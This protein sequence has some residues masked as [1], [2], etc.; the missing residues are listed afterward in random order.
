MILSQRKIFNIF[1]GFIEALSVVKICP[2]TVADTLMS[3]YHT[4]TSG[5]TDYTLTYLVLT[6]NN[7]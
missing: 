4:V 6:K 7:A 3:T 2:H 1:P 5:S